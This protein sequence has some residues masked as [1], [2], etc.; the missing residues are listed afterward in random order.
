MT[1]FDS[2]DHEITP[3][4]LESEEVDVAPFEDED[5]SEFDLSSAL[6]TDTSMMMTNATSRRESTASHGSHRR[7]SMLSSKKSSD[8]SRRSLWEGSEVTDITQGS[9]GKKGRSRQSGRRYSSAR[10][11]S[12]LG[13]ATELLE[14]GGKTEVDDDDWGEE[15]GVNYYDP[16]VVGSVAVEFNNVMDLLGPP[17][18]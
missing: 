18:N 6:P 5:L 1:H 9:K 2:D 15:E 4:Q 16:A 10:R 3:F 13:E 17:P 7:R 8:R 12:H 11:E 14:D